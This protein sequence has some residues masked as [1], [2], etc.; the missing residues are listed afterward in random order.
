MFAPEQHLGAFI[1]DGEDIGLPVLAA[2]TQQFPGLLP[3]DHESLQC[4]VRGADCNAA[5]P[6]FGADPLPQ[7]VVA[8]EHDYLIGIAQGG[9]DA[10][11]DQGADRREEKRR[12]GDMADCLAVG[13]IEAGNRVGFHGIL[14]TD[15]L[16][17]GDTI[18]FRGQ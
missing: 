9:M 15:E 17:V 14:G 3:G 11:G 10:P 18:R 12:V 1:E 4:Q 5:R 13:V 7:G 6:V 2:K 16:E 8:I